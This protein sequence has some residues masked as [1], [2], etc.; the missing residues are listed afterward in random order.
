MTIRPAS[1]RTSTASSISIEMA[2]IMAAGIRTA[3][4]LPHFF[5]TLFTTYAPPF[6]SYVN[7]CSRVNNVDTSRFG[8]AQFR[9]QVSDSN[10]GSESFR[11]P[12]EIIQK[13]HERFEH[14]ETVVF[15]FA[16]LL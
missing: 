10:L 7:P 12:Q 16:L 1:S 6:H 11:K 4:L 15:C 9:R 8:G 5:T 13:A 14:N 2:P 3:A